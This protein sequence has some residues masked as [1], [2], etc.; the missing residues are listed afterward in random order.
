MSPIPSFSYD[1][2]WGERSIISVANLSR[3]DGI[4]FMKLALR[5]PIKT[6]IEIFPLE[7]A[8]EALAALRAG[9]IRGAGVLVP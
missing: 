6:E 7:L 4:E 1:L 3:A 8:D 9:I 2:L 5:V